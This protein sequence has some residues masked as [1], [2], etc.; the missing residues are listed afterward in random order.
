MK[1]NCCLSLQYFHHLTI[2]STLFTMVTTLLICLLP[3][4]G[5]CWI[6]CQGLYEVWVR[7]H[8]GIYLSTTQSNW[9]RVVPCSTLNLGREVYRSKMSS[10]PHSCPH[11]LPRLIG[12]PERTLKPPAMASK[13][14]MLPISHCHETLE[15]DYLRRGNGSCRIC[16]LGSAILRGG[17]S[18]RGRGCSRRKSC[19][20]SGLAF[21]T[22]RACALPYAGRIRISGNA[23]GLGFALFTE[24]VTLSPSRRCRCS[25]L[26][27]RYYLV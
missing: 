18:A 16:S 6:P 24:Q 23:S 11:Q 21:Y 27:W 19:T 14:I 26:R 13:S 3:R 9:L 15:L 17:C 5:R 25:G 2:E 20:G 22:S 7:E 12:G 8:S 10:S 4:L 1:R